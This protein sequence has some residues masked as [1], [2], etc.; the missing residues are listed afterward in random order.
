[1]G[2]DVREVSEW[3]RMWVRKW[4]NIEVSEYVSENRIRLAIRS[5]FT[6][7]QNY[8]PNLTSG[9]NLNWFC[10]R[11]H[12]STHFRQIE[13]VHR[14]IETLIDSHL[15]THFRQIEVVHRQIETL[16]DSHLSTHFRQIEVVQRQLE[17]LIDSCLS[18]DFINRP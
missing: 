1:M 3:M 8:L 9:H 18:T 11:T 12:L 5:N 14:Q 16:I 15:S 10:I 7:F 17:T 2:K 4:M 13:V 6:N